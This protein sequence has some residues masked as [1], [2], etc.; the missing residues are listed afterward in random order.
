MEPTLSNGDRVLVD[1]GGLVRPGAIVVA[2]HPTDASVLV[3]RV[4]SLG[5]GTVAIG[6]DDPTVGVDSRQ[7]GTI[8]RGDV[9]GTVTAI[10]RPAGC[11]P[12]VLLVESGS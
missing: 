7:L 9:L 11:S 5:R 3:K 8:A 4:R 1:S 6:S 2:Q 10:L 12:R